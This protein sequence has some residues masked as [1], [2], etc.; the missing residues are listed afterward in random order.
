[1]KILL[2]IY[3]WFLLVISLISLPFTRFSDVE[4]ALQIL[5]SF[6][7]LIPFYAYLYKRNSTSGFFSRI[8]IGAF[9]IWEIYGYTFIYTSFFQCMTALIICIP[10]YWSLVDYALTTSRDDGQ[11][12]SDD[13]GQEDR[14]IFS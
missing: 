5:F 14:D 6:G 13:Q 1:M 11:V 9:F 8:F 4:G 2:K 7:A 12:L 3:F 10:L